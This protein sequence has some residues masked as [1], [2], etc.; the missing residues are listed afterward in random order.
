MQGDLYALQVQLP[1][2]VL[3][4]MQGDLYALQVQIP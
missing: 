1:L 3:S 4:Q 2:Q